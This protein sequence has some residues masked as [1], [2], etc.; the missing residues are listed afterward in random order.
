MRFQSGI[1]VGLMLAAGCRDGT[2][3]EAGLQKN[4]GGGGDRT[5]S[6][7]VIT[8]TMQPD[9]HYVNVAGVALTLIKTSDG[10]GVVPPDSTVPTMFRPRSGILALDGGA[11]S[12]PG[13]TV[14]TPPP[15][16]CGGGAD[17]VGTATSDDQG[18]FS[19]TGLAAGRYDLV[20]GRSS[21]NYPNTACGIDLQ[22]QE[23][24]EL[25][26]FVATVPSQP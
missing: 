19:F 11:D 16:P 9:S 12:V 25:Q 6:G 13:D 20:A 26:L 7:Q 2:S 5:I 23:S 1:V 15:D 22:N 10:G 3:P 4:S 8:L 18:H 24:S 17:T 21:T 14:H